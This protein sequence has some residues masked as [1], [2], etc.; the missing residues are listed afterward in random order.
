MTKISIFN[1]KNWILNGIFPLKI[2]CKILNSF[3]IKKLIF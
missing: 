1:N 3:V 2:A